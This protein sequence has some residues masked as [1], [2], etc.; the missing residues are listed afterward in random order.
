[1][2]F[3]K[4]FCIALIIFVIAAIAFFFSNNSAKQQEVDSEEADIDAEVA[5][6]LEEFAVEPNLESVGQKNNVDETLDQGLKPRKQLNPDELLP[7]DEKID[8]PQFGEK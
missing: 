7:K 4:I 3:T 5:K 2:N 6:E 1:M 8:E